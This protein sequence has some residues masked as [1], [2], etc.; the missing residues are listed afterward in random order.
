M[1]NIVELSPE[2]TV[3]IVDMNDMPRM[4]SDLEP[5]FIEACK[6]SNGESS[7]Q[8]IVDSI[9]S[10]AVT[11]VAFMRGLV[12]QSIL[13]LTISQFGTGKRILEVVLA[14]GSGMRDWMKFETQMDDL[15]RSYGCHAIRMIGREG[16]QR[17]LPE[18]KRT[19]IVLERSV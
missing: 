15:A 13:I 10:G 19:A 1:K 6:H 3:S 4:W 7:P 12:P 9:L 14:S 17:M 18:W 11:L 5:L 8:S 2:L 16:L